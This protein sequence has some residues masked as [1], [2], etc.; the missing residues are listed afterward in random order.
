MVR[1]VMS[2]PAESTPSNGN[3]PKSSPKRVLVGI[4][5]AVV[6]WGVVLAAGTYLYRYEAGPDALDGQ[7]AVRRA[8]V[9]LGCTFGF[10][11]FWGVMLVR[12][13]VG[14][15]RGNGHDR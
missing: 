14:G 2:D 3:Q 12:R 5:L 15:S 1:G 10:L 9:V 8:V 7:R 4:M 6:V 13:T 11:A